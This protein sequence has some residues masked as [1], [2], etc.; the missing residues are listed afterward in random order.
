MKAQRQ[1]LCGALSRP[2]PDLAL[3]SHLKRWHSGFTL[4]ELLVVI[5]IIAVLAAI[6]FPVFAQAKMAAR[7]VQSLSNLR[8]TGVAWS[9]YDTDA[10]G[11]VMRAW[12]VGIDR[13]FYWWGSWDGMLFRERE[14]LL[15]P[16]TKSHGIAT[17]PTF[18]NA[19][20]TALGLTGYGYNYGYL[21][22]NDYDQNYNEI[23]RPVNESQVEQPVE[24]L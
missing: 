12:T 2:G 13:T 21:S 22:P 17:D 23:P 1:P 20:R 9:L 19:L 6:L 3:H 15:F 16:Y 14:G 5:A 4:I 7:K 24:T 8:Q 11:T 10:E 18:P